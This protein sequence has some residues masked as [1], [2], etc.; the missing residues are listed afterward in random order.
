MSGEFEEFNRLL[1]EEMR[2]VYSEKAVDHALHPRN[3]GN[4]P[5]ANSFGM[6]TDSHGDSL[7]LWLRI[8]NDII[9]GASFFTTGCITIVAAGS[10]AT[11]L[12]KGMSLTA[13]GKLTSEDVLKVL[14]GLPKQTE[15]CAELAVDALREAVA[16]YTFL[17]NALWN[18][19]GHINL[20][21]DL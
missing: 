9:T 11:E 18:R 8:E 21:L 15:H 4:L 14:G 2:S 6:A 3:V 17:K 10:A 16:R 13:A 12:V 1:M 5:D 19:P 20:Q 7:Q